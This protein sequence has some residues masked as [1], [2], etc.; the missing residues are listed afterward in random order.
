[1]GKPIGQKVMISVM[2][3]MIFDLINAQRPGYHKE[4]TEGVS[5]RCSYPF[6][7]MQHTRL[8]ETL[9]SLRERLR[10]MKSWSGNRKRSGKKLFLDAGCG[11]GNVMVTARA[12]G[13]CDAY[14]GIE[15]F[16]ETFKKAQAWLGINERGNNTYKLFQE[17]ILK[18]N[19]YGKYDIIYFYCP[20]S[21]HRLQR[22]FEERL[23]D[24]MKVGAI[25]IGFLKQ[26]RAIRKDY[27]FKRIQGINAAE[28]VFIKVKKGPRKDSEV[29]R[30]ITAGSVSPDKERLYAEK[31][32]LV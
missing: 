29:E 14:H 26:S 5:D 15:F 13:L 8:I 16:D 12:A 21:D 1:M 17:D 22:R 20:F 19:H 9:V 27:R 4:M 3:D 23:E 2:S 25:L 7:P 28:N 18:F 31:Y 6:I 30:S 24:E 11:P 10:D 32:N